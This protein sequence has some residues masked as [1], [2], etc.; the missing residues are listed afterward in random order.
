MKNTLFLLAFF[1]A[2]ALL[3]QDLVIL[4]T[5]D[6]HSH[7]NGLAPETEYTPLVNDNDPTLGGFSR[8]AGFIKSERE[9]NGNKVIVV[10]A[11]DFLMG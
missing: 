7:F 4:H 6:L 2:N 9:K 3:A 11:G 1:A 10:D 5:N 8:I